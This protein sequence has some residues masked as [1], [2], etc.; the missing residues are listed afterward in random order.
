[1]IRPSYLVFVLIECFLYSRYNYSFIIIDAVLKI[2][3]ISI[4]LY[5]YFTLDK[6]ILRKKEKELCQRLTHIALM[7]QSISCIAVAT[8]PSVECIF[9]LAIYTYS[10][11]NLLTKY[12]TVRSTVVNPVYQYAR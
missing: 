9:K 11:I 12:F 5:F 4:F 7:T 3:F 8:G 1:M 6:D 2:I 10:V